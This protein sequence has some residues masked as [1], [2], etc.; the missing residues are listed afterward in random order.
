[1][2]LR[3]LPKKE[4]KQID[5]IFPKITTI[6]KHPDAVQ[7]AIQYTKEWGEGSDQTKLEQS[8]QIFLIIE[9]NQIIGITGFLIDKQKN[10]RLGWH[11]IIPEARGNNKGATIITKIIRKIHTFTQGKTRWLIETMPAHNTKLYDYFISQ[12]FT[13]FEDPLADFFIEYTKGVSVRIKINY[14]T[15]S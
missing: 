7:K 2:K 14:G 5:A 11:G 8:G 1:M 15:K 12:G 6:W 4:A 10:A 3:L 9:K 13:P